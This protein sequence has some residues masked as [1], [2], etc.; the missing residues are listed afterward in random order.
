MIGGV[1][2]PL[3]PQDPTQRLQT[4]VKETQCT[5]VIVHTLTEDK[6][7]KECVTMNIDVAISINHVIGYSVSDSSITSDSIAY[8]IFTSGSTGIPKAA[9]IRHRNFTESV[10]SLIEVGTFNEKDIVLQMA[11]C[12]FDIHVEDIL[13]ILIT[14][15]TLVMLRPDGLMDFQYLTDVI[16]GKSITFINSVPSYLTSL[17]SYL[18]TRF[19][20]ADWNRLRSVVCGGEPLPFQLVDKLNKHLLPKRRST[21]ACHIWNLYGPAEVTLD[22]LYHNIELRYDQSSV[23]V[24]R[25]LPGYQCVVLDDFLEP[26]F[27]GQEGELFV[28]GVGIFAGYLGR[29]NLNK[30]VLVMIDNQLFY[31]TGDLVR[32][33]SDQLFYYIG[34]KDHQVKLHGQRIE[35]GEIERCLL[36]LSPHVSAC[37]VVKWD[38]DHLIA[39][40]Q[41]IDINEERLRQHCQSRL[42]LFM[43]PS[44]FVILKHLPMNAN[45]KLDRKLLPVPDSSI[46]INEEHHT[47]P[48]NGIE[49]RIHSLWCEVLQCKRISTT[50]NIFTIG[51]HSLLLIQLYHR[52]KTMFKFDTHAINISN[53][54]QHSTIV[55]HARFIEQAQNTRQQQQ[56]EEKWLPLHI[57]QGQV[58][59]AQERIFLDE[60]IRFNTQG[61]RMYEVRLAHV[62]SNQDKFLSIERLRRAIQSVLVKHS[63]LR[64][65]IF[66]NSTGTITQSQVPINDLN[67]TLF[68][69]TVLHIDTNDKNN[70]SEMIHHSNLF[71]LTEGRLL[72]CHLLLRQQSSSLQSHDHLSTNDIILFHI[73]HSAFDGASTPIFMR[74]LSLAYNQDSPLSIDENTL[75]YIDYSL[76]ERQ[77]DMTSA[78]HFWKTLLHEYDL[79]SELALP[80]DRHRLPHKERSGKAIVAQITFDHQLSQSFLDYAHSSNVTPFQLGLSIFFVF[81]M[82]LTNGQRDLCV[83]S[84][85][86]N[87]YRSELEDLIGMFVATLPYRLQFDPSTSFHQLVKQVQ[88]LCFSILEHSHYP[89]QHIIDNQH[90][91]AFLEI[92]YDFIPL[93]S[94]NNEQVIVD[95]NVLEPISLEKDDFVA[96]FDFMLTLTEKSSDEMSCSL[97]CSEDRFDH[98]TVQTL[99][100]RFTHLF[101]Q[102]FHP[103][104]SSLHTSSPLYKLSLI[105]PEEQSVIDSMRN[106]DVNRPRTSTRTIP[107]LFSE[108]VMIHPQK[109]G[110]EL[111]EQ[112]LSYGELYFYTQQ[113]GMNLINIYNVKEGDIVCQ[114]VERSISMV[115]GILSIEMI[116]GVYCPLSPQDPT[117]RLQTLVKETQSRLIL[118][119]S[120]TQNKLQDG[121]K[122]VNMD[123][124]LNMNGMINDNDLDR[125]SNI[126]VTVESI[127]YIIFTSGST[128]VPKAAQFRQRNF[129]EFTRS[130]VEVGVFDENDT[131]LQ[132][133]K[134]SFDI[135][136]EDLIG[137]FVLGASLI[138]L[139][140]DGLMDLPYLIDTIEKKEITYFNSVPSYLATLCS[141]LDKRLEKASLNHVRS[142]CSGGETLPIQLIHHLNKHFSSTSENKCHIW[143]IYGPA[144]ITIGCT[145]QLVDSTCQQS[146]I[147]IGPL[148]PGYRCLIIDD[149]GEPVYVGQ[150]GELLI[151]GVGVYSGY[152]GR[153]DLTEK[154]LTHMHGELFYRTG[155][156]VHVDHNCVIHYVG[157]KDHQV[158]LRGQRIELGEIERCLR[159]AS[160]NV[161]SSVVVKSGKDHLIAYVQGYDIDKDKL[162]NYCRSH[163]AFFMIPSLIIVLEQFP[164][165]PNGKLDRKLLPTPDFS[166]ITDCQ[167]IDQ[168]KLTELEERLLPIFAQAFHVESPNVNVPFGQFGGTSLDVIIALSMIRQQI[169]ENIGITTLYENPSIRQ[170]AQVL[171]PLIVTEEKDK[172][173]Q[174][175]EIL[176]TIKLKE[177][178]DHQQHILPSLFIETL[179]IIFLICQWLSPIWMMYHSNNY[180]SILLIPLVHLCMYVICQRLLLCSENQMTKIDSLY[181]WNYY[182]WWFLERLWTINNSYWLKHVFGTSLYNFYLRLCGARIG[183]GVHIY[184]TFIDAPWLLEIGDSTF[185][186]TDVIFSN[187]SY[188]IQTYQLNRIRIGSHCSIGTRCVLYD[189]VTIEDK[190]YIESMS[191]VTGHFSSIIKHSS[192]NHRS[193]SWKQIIYQFILLSCLLILHGILLILTFHMYQLYLIIW[194][195]IPIAIAF[196]CLF[197]TITSLI[198]VM[199]LLKFLVGCVTPGNYPVNSYYFLR[200]IWFRQLIISSFHHSFDLFSSYNPISNTLLCWLN[201]E[202]GADV[203]LGE[204]H[205]ILSFP[206]NLLRIEQ[207]VTTFAK[208][209]LS[210]YEITQTGDCHL[211]P[212]ILG[213]YSNLGNGCTLM[214]GTQLP[215]KTMVGNLTLVTRNTSISA[216][217]TVLVGIPAR[218]MPFVMPKEEQIPSDTFPSLNSSSF[219][220][221]TNTCIIYFLGKC[222]FI[223]NYYLFP[224]VIA[225]IV[226][227]CLFCLIHRCSI[228]SSSSETTLTYSQTINRTHE[229]LS[230]AI[231][232]FNLFLSPFLSKTQYL[233][234][235]FR[236]LGAHI[237]KDVILPSIDCLTDPHLVTI[238]NHVRLQRDSCLQSHTFEQRIFKLA[239]IH[240]QDST[241]LMSYSNVLAGSI[242]HG[243]NRLYPLT[244]VM[245]YDQLPMNTI[246]SD[247]P[248]RRID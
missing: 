29:D 162:H 41:S 146:T 85:C 98:S 158:K 112:M 55:D 189:E 114:C 145:I 97:I 96:K 183:H 4:L 68:G 24:G 65:S 238:G 123:T 236:F 203:K 130:F 212:I 9:Q 32:L 34:R 174:S 186:D 157:R 209:R 75:N 28:G 187:L 25:L 48:K 172:Q 110:V 197:W 52:Y 77:M 198:I 219:Y 59:F 240:V 142:I 58:S 103:S 3:S 247:V 95:G 12:S 38:N 89:L 39:Y 210:S 5:V 195:P 47:E 92:M 64:T 93:S 136:V 45:G 216:C 241:V 165:N 217:G 106:H 166:A 171:E 192:I 151:A 113:L 50:V 227:L 228:L 8:I 221:F 243:R 105:L 188:D 144:E 154:A 206:S 78:K 16:I 2:C 230:T 76:Y 18:E 207:G 179:G 83:G 135:H 248:A 109:M 27:T 168:W 190:T 163:L 180:F 26:V 111:D 17:C 125:L 218:P 225:P 156:L 33:N 175:S 116:G 79:E 108:Q 160:S 60:Q 237:G 30:E 63:V 184:S 138:M 213:S 128:G 233:V 80:F 71:N 234:N 81:L 61:G 193:F 223:S 19:D 215:P 126:N 131:V 176:T 23:P 15:G 199:F 134:C 22:C 107:Q 11:R 49:K 245:K 129:L 161:T 67:Q 86:A 1:Y 140:P 57:A 194:I 13:G 84:V 72:H 56:Q 191:K 152:L 51:G 185:I 143:N 182:R 170:L 119:D 239:P 208:V 100:Q 200:R 211:S 173:K 202:I 14:G 88:Q 177:E 43:I 153:D 178:D 121:E 196:S 127:G 21:D 6:F 246:W 235:L 229:F 164:L 87:R 31:R 70:I 214:P 139:R 220:A 148:I 155:D 150:E 169:S 120:L 82:K 222:L 159:D 205:P 132:T 231:I 40:L 35:L 201:A 102:L 224:I 53:M 69:F 115:I 46:P 117:Q 36:D 37:V 181:S 90:S 91:P 7:D 124:M 54:F 141:Y 101:S 94:S 244:L 10:R 226:H 122:R 137:T 42:P 149:F 20:D 133:T 118:V 242:L 204:F 232:E 74:D 104:I 62:I 66:I 147:P 167:R 44:T 99:L 73:H